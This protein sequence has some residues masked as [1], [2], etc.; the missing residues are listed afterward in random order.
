MN[1]LELVGAVLLLIGQTSAGA[2]NPVGP[3]MEC[4]VVMTDGSR[5]KGSTSNANLQVRSAV[6]KIGVSLDLLTRVQ[7]QPDR[8]T[9][10]MTFRNGDRIS[11]VID[12]SGFALQTVLGEIT[13]PFT[14]MAT[15]NIMA[16]GARG[17]TAGE[18]R[19]FV[20]GEIYRGLDD[21]PSAIRAKYGRSAEVADWDDI[22]NRFGG[23]IVSFLDEVGIEVANDGGAFVTR[24]G[25]TTFS[26]DRAYYLTR[27]GGTKPGHYLAH[28]QIGGHQASLGSWNTSQKVLVRVP[29]ALHR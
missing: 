10:V 21:Y 15:W 13:I 6:G 9:V 22:K 1:P 14:K 19:Y 20:T 16:S 29:V 11:G 25:S 4:E 2:T 26:P 7:M 23:D 5:L 18:W 24:G 8:E 3:A 12:G 27:H 17:K 28:D